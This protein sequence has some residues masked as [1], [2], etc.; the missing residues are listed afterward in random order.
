MNL[1]TSNLACSW[2]FPRPI[3]K[4]RHKKCRC[5]SRLGELPKICK[6]TFNISATVD[7]SD[8]KFGAQV[9]RLPRTIIKLHA[10]EKG[11]WPWTRGAPQKF[12]FG[13]IYTIAKGSDFTQLGIAKAHHE[14]TPMGKSG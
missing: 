2:N 3:I 9:S 5:G 13:N 1:A 11:V 10:E 14:L 4:S 12:V 7:A 6:L 8:F